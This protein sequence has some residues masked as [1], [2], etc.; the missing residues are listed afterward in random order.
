VPP[1]LIGFEPDRAP[2]SSRSLIEAANRKL[3]QGICAGKF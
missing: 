1:S 2:P 3:T